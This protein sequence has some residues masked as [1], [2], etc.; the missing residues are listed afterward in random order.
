M[1]IQFSAVHMFMF[2]SPQ[3]N[4]LNHRYSGIPLISWY[5]HFWRSSSKIGRSRFPTCPSFHLA[6][7]LPKEPPGDMLQL[8][9]L[10]AGDGRFEG[11]WVPDETWWNPQIKLGDVCCAGQCFPQSVFAFWVVS[12]PYDD[13]NDYSRKFVHLQRLCVDS[14]EMYRDCNL[15]DYL[16]VSSGGI[17]T[18]GKPWGEGTCK[19]RENEDQGR[20][21]DEKLG[22][23]HS[24]T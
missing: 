5:E 6:Q 15:F 2:V 11:G 10:Y 19:L 17:S 4:L 16:R 14:I 7:G 22:L 23:R 24:Q 21:E 18:W 12:I 8:S 9:L 3:K 20:D 1:N 13:Y